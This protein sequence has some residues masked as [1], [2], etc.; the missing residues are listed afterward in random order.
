[1]KIIVADDENWVRAVIVHSIPE[2]GEFS[3]AGEASDGYEALALC[4]LHKPEVL[5]TDIQMPGMTGL[6]LIHALSEEAPDTRIIIISGYNDFEYAKSAIRYGVKEYLLKPVDGVELTNALQK[7][8]REIEDNQAF[9]EEHSRLK[10]QLE[11]T[12]PVLYEKFLN[13]LLL[14]NTYTKNT[15]LNTLKEYGVDFHHQNFMV[16]V[17]VPHTDF[18]FSKPLNLRNSRNRIEKISNRYFKAAAIERPVENSQAVIVIINHEAAIP[19]EK[20]NR[21]LHYSIEVIRSETGM[22]ASAGASLSSNQLNQLPALFT[23]ALQALDMSFFKGV[24]IF[25]FDKQNARQT[26]TSSLKPSEELM[27]SMAQ[28]VRLSDLSFVYTYIGEKF[29]EFTNDPLISSKDVKSYFQFF[30]QVLFAKMNM[31]FPWKESGPMNDIFTSSGTVSQMKQFIVELIGGIGKQYSESMQNECRNPVETALRWIDENYN[32]DIGIEKT[33][34][35]VH[36]NTTYFSELFKKEV[37]ISFTEYKIIV[38][39]EHAKRLLETTSY[40]I[41]EI[42]KKVG[43][44]DHKYFSELF[45][46]ITGSSPLSFKQTHVKA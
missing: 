38:R 41:K 29:L 3:L 4:K 2:N 12:K 46:R 45:K 36:L 26:G 10:F 14:Q 28:H 31:E 35:F 24:G 32:Q 21:L 44:N 43:Y 34:K 17:M 19:H 27:E 7:V 23:Q 15:I 1:M 11:Q 13:K 39:I 6:E 16:A 33:A 20:M 37:G 40:S 22:S 30:I 8:K 9:Q 18:I 5:L 42:S 25:Y